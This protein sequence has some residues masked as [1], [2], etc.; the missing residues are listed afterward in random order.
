MYTLWHYRRMLD[1]PVRVDAYARA[2]RAQVR[3]DD[4]VLDLGCGVGVF[5]VLAARLGARMVYGV[6]PNPAVSLAPEVA[7][8]NAVDSRVRFLRGLVED[9]D[10]DPAPT[11]LVGDVRGGL[12]FSLG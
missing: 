12:P 1:D 10:L 11:L 6:E 8:E 5:A 3:P 2:L 9:V 7:R 4:V